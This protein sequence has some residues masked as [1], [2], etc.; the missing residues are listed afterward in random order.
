MITVFTSTYNRE[1]TLARLYYS[2]VSQMEQNF[3]WLIIDDG[4]VDHTRM[5]VENFQKEEKILIRYYYQKNGGKQRAINRAVKLAKGEL[6]FIVDS[7][8]FL[9]PEALKRINTEWLEVHN[10][11]QYAGLCFRKILASTGRALGDS[12]PFEKFDTNSLE[13]TYNYK[14]KVDKAEVFNTIV[15]KRYPFPEIEN[16]NFV[17][18]A[19]VWFRIAAAGYRLRCIDQGIYVCEY[20]PDGLTQNFSS[21]LK[22]NNRG[23][24][25][26]YRELLHYKQPTLW[27]DK[28]KAFI[29]LL[30]CELYGLIR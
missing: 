12:F 2:L 15:L 19:L 10:K 5:L 1:H 30:Q 23:F 7:D 25:M 22:K 6:F 9:I 24:G 27:P 20:L 3:E 13:L 18:E 14:G 29:R 4:S 11:P 26:F 16:E 8:D 17:P 28:V 21:N